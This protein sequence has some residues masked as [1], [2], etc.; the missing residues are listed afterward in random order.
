VLA[1]VGEECLVATS[2]LSTDEQGFLERADVACKD[3]CLL[4]GMAATT[5]LN[6]KSLAI[7]SARLLRTLVWKRKMLERAVSSGTGSDTKEVMQGNW[8]K[9]SSGDFV[10]SDFEKNIFNIMKNIEII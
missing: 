1:H 5:T 2:L 6:Q 3:L 7:L 4:H 8:L 10:I 9:D